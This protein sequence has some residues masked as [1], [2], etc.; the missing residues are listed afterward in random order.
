[1][2]IC[3]TP[4]KLGKFFFRECVERLSENQKIKCTAWRKADR[5]MSTSRSKSGPVKPFFFAWQSFNFVSPEQEFSFNS[6]LRV[7]HVYVLWMRFKKVFQCTV[8][9]TFELK[10]CSVIR[11]VCGRGSVKLR[12]MPLN[13][14]KRHLYALNNLYKLSC[15]SF[16]SRL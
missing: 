14:L 6:I 9:R 11:S 8:A 12:T 4:W 16:F 15:T 13:I 3:V 7:E 1:M 10:D 2:S 5:W